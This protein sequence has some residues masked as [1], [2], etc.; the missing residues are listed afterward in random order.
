MKLKK[1]EI[2]WSM[3]TEVVGVSLASYGLFLIFP[4]ISFIA[5]GAFLIWVTEKE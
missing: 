2:D 5:L 4:P 1:P 3:T